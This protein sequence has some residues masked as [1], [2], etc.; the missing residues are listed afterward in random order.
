MR[1]CAVLFCIIA[2]SPYSLAAPGADAPAYPSNQEITKELDAGKY[3]NASENLQKALSSN[4][5]DAQAAFW[6]GRCFWEMGDFE[7]AVAYAERAVQMDPS[8]SETH[9]WL[10]RSYGLK[11]E[12]T[13]NLFLARK[14]REEFE[15]AVQLDP[16][17]LV[18]R[19]NLM[20][21]YLE[22][23]WFLG[24]SKDK[25]WNQVEAIASRNA[26]EGYLARGDFWREANNSSLAAQNYSEVLKLRPQS[27]E[28]YFEVADFYESKANPELVE[29]AVHAASRI[30]PKD[31]RLAY[32]RGVVKVLEGSDLPE[33]QKYF[34]EYLLRA[35]RRGDFP[36]HA[37]AHDWLGRIYERWG[38]VQDAI[39]QYKT[40]LDLSPD[41][42]SARD[43][44]RRLVS[45]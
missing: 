31:P 40:A 3:A 27:A 29:K 16:N 7:R 37:S 34:E 28:P 21:Y 9:L 11:A 36:S 43:S 14:S 1:I 13:H 42:Q 30:E 2:L 10:A 18:A 38:K 24:G 45:N 32:Y 22:A 41:N 44:L 15:T 17:N 6:L 8:R 25:A 35:P 20:E 23:P 5:N 19:R 33:A 12:K 39:R 4:P 26:V